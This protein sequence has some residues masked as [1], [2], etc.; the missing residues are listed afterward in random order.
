M[1]G[2]RALLMAEDISYKKGII[3]SY[4]QI[5]FNF[6]NIGD[7]QE[8]NRFIKMLEDQYQDDIDEDKEI[9]LLLYD[10][11]GRNYL[12]LGFRKQAVRE[13]KKE[14]VFVT[15][16]Q[17]V[18]KKINIIYAYIQLSACYENNNADSTY[19]YLNKAKA[20]SDQKNAAVNPFI[21]YNLSDYHLTFS[22]N[23]DSAFYYNSKAL[24]IEEKNI[25]SELYIGYYQKA[26]ILFRQKKYNESLQY[27]FKVIEIAKK[28]KR[29]E[30]LIS[31]YKLIADNYVILNNSKM[32]TK[33][34]ELY[35]TTKDSMVIARRKGIQASADSLFNEEEKI[36]DERNNILLYSILF[37]VIFIILLIFIL[38][39]NRKRVKKD[40]RKVEEVVLINSKLKSLSEGELITM[41]KS[42]SPDFLYRCKEIYPEFFKKLMEIQP[43]LINSELIFCAYLKLNFSSKDIANHTFVTIK[44]VQNRK[45]RIRKRLNIPSESD[46]YIWFNTL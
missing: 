29:T 1:I 16:Y 34:T 3:N 13:F 22:K 32:F 21:Y 11:K 2:K 27:A 37:I 28:K 14:L 40:L 31:A 8:S 19:Y 5:A 33:Y 35:V 44:A 41:A 26:N 15:K 42:N 20:A 43:A 36:K 18:S 39:K 4:Y 45:N 17:D 10:L 23:L 30:Q 7:Y 24:E 46:L 38:I 25:K 9:L 6:C 12:A